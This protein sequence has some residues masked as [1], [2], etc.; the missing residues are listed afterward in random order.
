MDTKPNPPLVDIIIPG[1]ENLPLL[2][3]C[4][5]SLEANTDAAHYNVI[6]V[7]N[8][9][10]PQEISQLIIDYPKITVVH[11]P[12]AVGFVRAVNV[13]MAFTLMSPSPFVMWLNN[14][15][16]IPAGDK[17]WLARMLAPFEQAQVGAVG[18]VSDHI[19][20]VQHR[21]AKLPDG[22][23]I[24]VPILIGFACMF[25]KDAIK[26]IGFLDERFSP[27]N[28]EDWDYCLRLRVLGWKLIINEQVWVEHRMHQTFGKMNIDFNALL[29]LNLQKLIGKWGAANMAAMGIETCPLTKTGQQSK[30]P[31]IGEPNATGQSEV[32]SASIDA[33]AIPTAA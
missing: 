29:N 1:W 15:T 5:R 11:I 27:G 8:G 4:L 3:R 26:Q 30:G 28:Y 22:D 24:D 17:E 21:D 6:Y 23:W 10:E 18:P 19:Y 13:G 33:A 2:R 25:R 14:D 16:E 7:D 32:E 31:G 20:G 12:R 9:T